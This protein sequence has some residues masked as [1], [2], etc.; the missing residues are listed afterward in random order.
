MHDGHPSTVTAAVWLFGYG[1]LIYKVDFEFLERRP[2]QLHGWAR[3]FW[4]GSH[5]HRG[6][7]DAP[8]RVATLVREPGAVCRGVAYRITPSVFTH[9]DHREKNGYVRMADTVEFDDGS[10]ASCVVYVADP[11]NE[12]WLGP[13]SDRSIAE[14]IAASRGPSG[15]N[16]E[17]LLRLA[18]ALRE[19]DAHDPHVFD[20]ERALLD[21][22]RR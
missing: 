19:L 10:R 21:R 8:G 9:L 12:A 18:Q 13:A 20:L 4:Q 7:P 1:S 22:S 17:Y 3:R 11:G 6:T 16:R 15:S 5:D 2:A 14:H